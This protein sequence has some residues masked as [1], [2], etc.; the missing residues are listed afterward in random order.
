MTAA[1]V[2]NTGQVGTTRR[3][4]RMACQG[5]KNRCCRENQNPYWSHGDLPVSSVA[6]TCYATVRIKFFAFIE[7]INE[8]T[9]L[10]HQ[11]RM[12]CKLNK[13][14]TSINTRDSPLS[15]NAWD[16]LV[17]LH[18]IIDA[19]PAAIN[20]S[21]QSVPKFKLNKKIKPITQGTRPP[22]TK[23]QTFCVTR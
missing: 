9:S 13:T 5:R 3:E 22:A 15:P 18:R 10:K 2:R 20:N 4:Q 17:A 19:T 1:D 6:A 21:G 16:Y 8:N 23:P 11:T 12:R 7:A 14:S